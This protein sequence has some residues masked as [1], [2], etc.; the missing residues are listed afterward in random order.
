M[1]F[2][3]SAQLIVLILVLIVGLTFGWALHPGGKKWRRRYDEIVDASNAYRAEIAGHLREA[4][5]RARAVDRDNQGLRRDLEAARARVTELEAR[6][7]Q[8]VAA[9]VVAAPAVEPVKEVEEAKVEETGAERPIL[10]TASAVPAELPPFAKAA[11]AEDVS[12]PEAAEEP[13]AAVE[14]EAVAPIATEAA[15][16]EE[17]SVHAE[18]AVAATEPVDAEFTPAAPA[19]SEA[20]AATEDSEAIPAE[21]EAEP[22]K[23]WFGWNRP[24]GAKPA[25]TASDEELSRIRGIDGVLASRLA[26]LDVKHYADITSLSDQDEMALEQRL[27]LPAGYITREQWRDQ[28]ALLASG[29]TVEHADRF[30]ISA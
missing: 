28:A 29:K 12:E 9:P 26:A 27:N 1:L 2:T 16:A 13:V 30:G 14:H 7:A 5:S 21:E 22:R 17:E 24:N 23:Y 4:E 18:E 11:D 8:M 25:S 15:T 6:P 19:A 20:G 10:A 3:T